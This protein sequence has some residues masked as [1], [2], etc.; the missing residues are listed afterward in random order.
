MSAISADLSHLGAHLES[1]A[2]VLGFPLSEEQAARLVAYLVL[3]ERW[4][5]V[6]PDRGPR[7]GADGGASHPR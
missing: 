2:D 4:N 5:R 1:G 7:A 3:L 6:Q